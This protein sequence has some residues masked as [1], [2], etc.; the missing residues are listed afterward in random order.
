MDMETASEFV[1]CT[2][3][4]WTANSGRSWDIITELRLD[5]LLVHSQKRVP[6]VLCVSVR[7]CVEARECGRNG[8]GMNHE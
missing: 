1:R 6:T 3:A 8:G 2:Y 4:S 5:L 7:V